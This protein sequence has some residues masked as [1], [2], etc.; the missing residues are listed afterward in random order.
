[1]GISVFLLD[2]CT[3]AWGS[4]F[5]N[6]FRIPSFQESL[7][8]PLSQI[9]CLSVCQFK[10]PN[11]LLYRAVYSCLIF[12]P[13]GSSQGGLTLRKQEQHNSLPKRIVYCLL[14]NLSN[15]S[16][17]LNNSPFPTSYQLSCFPSLVKIVKSLD[18]LKN[19]NSFPNDTREGRTTYLIGA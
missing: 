3:F 15:S 6:S 8:L 9:L 16:H 4:D 7:P 14:G 18:S 5:S 19:T 2:I 10:F 11:M 13:V 1:M 12:L 17:L